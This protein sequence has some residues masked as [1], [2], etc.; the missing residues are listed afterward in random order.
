MKQAELNLKKC[1]LR[2]PY[3][4]RVAEV[5][6][7]PGGYVQP[8]TP[9]VTLLLMDPIKV[10]VAVSAQTDRQLNF[11]DFVAVYTPAYDR[12]M[13]GLGPL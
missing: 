3:D 11:G 5:H 9:V 7:I 10:T 6:V 2:A 1:T 12:P 8:G 13:Q 4:G